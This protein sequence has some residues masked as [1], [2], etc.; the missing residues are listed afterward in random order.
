MDLLESNLDLLR[1]LLTVGSVHTFVIDAVCINVC[2]KHVR[3]HMKEY[4]YMKA[5][6]ALREGRNN[7][8]I[9]HIKMPLTHLYL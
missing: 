8:P 7:L 4:N 1:P 2:D 9:L 5:F 6:R 3:K